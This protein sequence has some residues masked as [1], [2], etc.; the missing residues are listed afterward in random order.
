[1][2]E[3]DVPVNEED[4][5]F[6]VIVSGTAAVQGADGR[7]IARLGP[8]DFFGEM[9][10]LDEAPRSA[11]VVAVDKIECLAFRRADFVRNLRLYPDI[12]WQMMRTL[13]SRLRQELT[14]QH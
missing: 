12:G 4:D 14:P 9:A 11:A 6:Y 10:I 5:G 7:L 1:M 8:G 3:A 2:I 13:S